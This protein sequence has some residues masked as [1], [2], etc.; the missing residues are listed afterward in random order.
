MT[1]TSWLRTIAAVFIARPLSRLG[2]S[3]AQAMTLRMILGV[4]AAGLMAAGPEWFAVAGAVFLLGFMLARSD[5]EMAPLTRGDGVSVGRYAAV[6]E[7]TF[8]ALAFAGLGI[9]LQASAANLKIDQLGFPAPVVMGVVAAVAVLIVLWLVQRLEV[10]D[11]RRAPEFDSL[12]G[13]EV[14]DMAL[15]IPFAL[16]S[17]WVE[18][19]LVIVSFGGAAFAGGLYMAHFRKFHHLT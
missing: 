2:V 17:G 3:R 16:W 9:G 11:G 7:V 5:A 8:I 4:L 15:I 18:G 13:F 10:I 14:A 19:L 6:S 12:L 1:T